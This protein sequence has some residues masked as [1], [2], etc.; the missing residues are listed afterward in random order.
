MQIIFNI[1]QNEPDLL[2]EFSL[3]LEELAHNE[4]A[5][6]RSRSKELLRRIKKL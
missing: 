6:I 1:S 2:R 4:S 5:G 3:I